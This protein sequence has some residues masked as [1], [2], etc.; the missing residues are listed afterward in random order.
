MKK[1][2]KTVSVEA[3][4]DQVNTSLKESTCSSETRMGMCT[5]LEQ[6]L[7]ASGNY[8]GFRYLDQNEV[9]KDQLPGVRVGDNGDCLT[10]EERFANTDESRRQYYHKCDF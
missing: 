3:I 9:P 2:R 4:V 6:V 7:M 10:Y 5:V 1:G 8:N